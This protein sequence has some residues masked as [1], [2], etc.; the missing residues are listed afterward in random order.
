LEI[1][2]GA[3]IGSAPPIFGEAMVKLTLEPTASLDVHVFLPNDAGAAGAAAPLVDVDVAQ[4]NRY[5]RE[6]QGPGSGLTFP[7]LFAKAGFHVEATE[8][9]GEGRTITGD[10]S[11]PRTPPPARSR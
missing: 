4:G 8:L 9:G 11:S 6:Q 2:S 7:K 3:A 1:S 5:H 10:G